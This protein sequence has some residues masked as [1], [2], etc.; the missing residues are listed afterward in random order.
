MT[1]KRRMINFDRKKSKGGRNSKTKSIEKTTPNKKKT[2][3]IIKIKFNELF[4]IKNFIIKR[5][6]YI[7]LQCAMYHIKNFLIKSYSHC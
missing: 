2:I 4:K 5:K 1:I 3:K 7:D 6:G